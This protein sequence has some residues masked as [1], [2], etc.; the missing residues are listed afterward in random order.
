MK[1]TKLIVDY[2]YSFLLAAIISPVKEFRLAWHIN[3]CL[4]IDLCKGRDL[5][6]NFV[7][8]GRILISNFLFESEYTTFRLLKNKACESNNTQKPYLIPEL[9]E[10][11]FFLQVAGEIDTI[12]TN[13][14]FLKLKSTE[15]IQYV[16]SINIEKLKSK[17]N[18]IID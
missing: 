5:E 1:V 7:K 6:Y 4:E 14:F 3:H 18:F 17:D 13:D 9:K 10:Y 16:E 8:Q 12:D 11:D 2:D 15:V